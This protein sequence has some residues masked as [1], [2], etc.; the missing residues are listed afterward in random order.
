MVFWASCNPCP[1]ASA[2]AEMVWASLKLR[3]I[4]VGFR[5]RKIQRTPSI[6]R[7]AAMK[8][9]TGETTIGISTLS[10]IADQCTRLAEA[11]AAP[12]RP[13][14]KACEEDDGRPKY[15]VMTFHEI[16]PAS[17]ARTTTRPALPSGGSI[18]ELT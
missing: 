13:P 16:A 14:I 15:H 12:T 2:E 9:I 8:P 7:K 4:R 10:L 1:R 6:S 17:A 5:R 3:L 11:I 18:T